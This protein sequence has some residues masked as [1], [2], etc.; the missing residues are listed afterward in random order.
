MKS[1]KIADLQYRVR[2]AIADLLNRLQSQCWADLVM[3]AMGREETVLPRSSSAS[4]RE[5]MQRTGCCYCGK[6]QAPEK[7]A[8]RE[9]K[10]AKS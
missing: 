10:A 2:F 1:T 7:M 9:A 4:C 6:F 8:E 5:D 3:W